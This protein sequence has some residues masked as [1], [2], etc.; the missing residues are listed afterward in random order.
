MTCCPEIHLQDEYASVLAFSKTT[1]SLVWWRDLNV[2]AYSIYGNA[3]QI[4]V[5]HSYNSPGSNYSY[6]TILSHSGDRLYYHP[7]GTTFGVPSVFRETTNDWILSQSTL[8]A[9]WA[10]KSSN[11]LVSKSTT[12][13]A[14]D[15]ATQRGHGLSSYGEAA[16]Y[17]DS[18]NNVIYANKDGTYSSEATGLSNVVAVFHVDS[19]KLVLHHHNPSASEAYVSRWDMATNT[20][21]ETITSTAT[22]DPA[23]YTNATST[24][25]VLAEPNI[26]LGGYAVELFDIA[27]LSSAIWVATG[28]ATSSTPY[29]FIPSDLGDFIYILLASGKIEKRDSSG[30]VWTHTADLAGGADVSKSVVD[31]SGN[32]YYIT[33]GDLVTKVDGSDGSKAWDSETVSISGGLAFQSLHVDSDYIYVASE[34]FSM[35]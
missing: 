33:G 8:F 31:S 1:G 14:G 13:S 32:L 30:T 15:S 3:S 24:R 25:F 35:A 4:I 17:I 11:T 34:R 6:T 9:G 20:V 5:G 28:V 21:E 18:S 16:V 29:E 19:Q 2:N 10:S 27:D 26:F 23:N 12:P 7:A 22:S